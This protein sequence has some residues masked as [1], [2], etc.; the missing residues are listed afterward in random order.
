MSCGFRSCHSSDATMSVSELWRTSATRIS[1][2]RFCF[3]ALVHRCFVLALVVSVIVLRLQVLVHSPIGGGLCLASS[4]TGARVRARISDLSFAVG[5]SP[6]MAGG[7]R[8]GGQ[9]ALVRVSRLI[10]SFRI[11]RVVRLIS[12]ICKRCALRVIS[13][14][15]KPKPSEPVP[16]WVASVRRTRGSVCAS[17]RGWGIPSPAILAP[18]TA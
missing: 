11:A 17:A 16:A 7:A 12:R 14:R 1:C 10:T 5:C 6:V 15:P 3:L 18:R 9:A 13:T 8:S 4:R 2:W